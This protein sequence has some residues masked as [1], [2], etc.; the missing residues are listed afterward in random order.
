MS[1]IFPSDF[2]WDEDAMLEFHASTS[3]GPSQQ[4]PR[5]SANASHGVSRGVEIPHTAHGLGEHGTNTDPPQR[6]RNQRKPRP[7]R[8]QLNWE[9]KKEII[10]K[11]YIDDDESLP[12]TMRIM[13]DEHSFIAP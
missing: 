6:A 4:Q 9:S 8:Q 7:K 2:H 11:L 5:H 3:S 13:E 10:K 12:T 1:S